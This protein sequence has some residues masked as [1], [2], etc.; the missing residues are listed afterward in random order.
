M[1][2]QFIVTITGPEL[3][4]MVNELAKITTDA[5]GKW[6]NMKLAHLEGQFACIFKVDIAE[7]NAPALKQELASHD[8]YKVTIA[9]PLSKPRSEF[10]M[11]LVIAAADR[12]GLVRDISQQLG[13]L[14]IGVD[15][16]DCRRVGTFQTGTMFTGT[17][18]LKAPV[19][20]SNRVIVDKLEELSY[21]MKITLETAGEAGTGY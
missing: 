18:I 10:T 8:E 12:S 19:N 2:I 6:S 11:R 15:E 4:G 20:L 3:P 13:D 16:L 1:N 14:E 17:F 21:E 9:E 5:G 7:E